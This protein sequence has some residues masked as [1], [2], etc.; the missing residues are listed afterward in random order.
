MERSVAVL[1]FENLSED[2]ENACLA[3]GI[4]DEILT[5]LSKIGES[6]ITRLDEAVQQQ[7]RKSA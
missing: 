5:R 4:Q 2:K 6:D 3:E 7:A 1:P